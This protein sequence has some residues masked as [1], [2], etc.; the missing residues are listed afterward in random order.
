MALVRR[1]SLSSQWAK[2]YSPTPS[3]TASSAK[4]FDLLTAVDATDVVDY[5]ASNI[6]DT[7]PANSADV[8]CDIYG[9]PGT[10]DPASASLHSANFHIF[11]SGRNADEPS[12]PEPRVSRFCDISSVSSVRQLLGVPSAADTAIASFRSSGVYIFLPGRN[13]V[14]SQIPKA[15]ETQ[16]NFLCLQRLDA[17]SFGRMGDLHI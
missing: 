3:I 15:G 9:L 11:L 6:W 1:A 16:F 14:V 2:A 12:N 10:A 17:Q 7:L 5:L 8:A 4:H 13:G